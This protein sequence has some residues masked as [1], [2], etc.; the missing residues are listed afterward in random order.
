MSTLR[1]VVANQQAV[2]LE[3]NPDVFF[4]RLSGDDRAPVKRLVDTFYQT[5]GGS[6]SYAALGYSAARQLDSAVR[7]L[8]GVSDKPALQRALAAGEKVFE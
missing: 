4:T 7:T 1:S 8:G 3:L 6:S 2:L 5:Y